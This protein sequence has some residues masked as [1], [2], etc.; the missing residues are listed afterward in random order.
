ME[1]VDKRPVIIEFNGL[2]GSGKTTIADALQVELQKHG[3]T[4]CRYYF[5]T[6]LFKSTRLLYFFPQYWKYL[7]V[8]AL[9]AKLLNDRAYMPR[10]LSMTHYI[11]MYREFTKD[12]PKNLMIVDQGI[13]QSFISLGHKKVLPESDK[14]TELIDTMHLNDVPLIMVNCHVRKEISN[15]RIVSRPSNGCRVEKM[16]DEDRRRTLEMQINNFAFIRTKVKRIYPNLIFLDINSEEPINISVKKV[17][18][19]IFDYE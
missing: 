4:T 13:I 10:I 6:H 8:G 12:S 19:A 7:K 2:P 11:R 9:Y 18:S 14:L 17:L 1:G 16:T 15:A 3:I 5:R